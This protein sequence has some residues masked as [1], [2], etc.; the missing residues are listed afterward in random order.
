MVGWLLSVVVALGL[1][2]VGVTALVAPRA[3][4]T[5]YGIVV[6]DPR[7]FAFI[8][9]MGVRDVVI[10]VLLGLLVEAG[11]RAALAW[12]ISATSLIAVVDLALVMA[13]RR[14][15]PPSSGRDGSGLRPGFLH[16]TGALLLLGIG[17]VVWAGG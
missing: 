3:S 8:R 11:T 9:A 16:A 10:G 1:T 4:A 13:D 2:A 7:A 15:A 14:S 6:D 5:Q 12:A 17:I